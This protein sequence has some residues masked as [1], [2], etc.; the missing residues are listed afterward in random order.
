MHAFAN[1]IALA[2]FAAPA[3][4]HMMMTFPPAL[5]APQNPQYNESSVDHSYLVPLHIDGS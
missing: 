5:R 3:F 2:V 1:A 4:G